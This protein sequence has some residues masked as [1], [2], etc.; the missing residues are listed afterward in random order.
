MFLFFL[1]LMCLI[2]LFVLLY[3]KVQR[4]ELFLIWQE[5]FY[6]G[7]HNRVAGFSVHPFFFRPLLPYSLLFSFIFPVYHP[8]MQTNSFLSATT[9]LK[10]TKSLTK[11]TISAHRGI[12]KGISIKLLLLGSN[13]T[14]KRETHCWQ[15]VSHLYKTSADCTNQP[16]TPKKQK[17]II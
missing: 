14:Q 4:Y 2:V 11:A 3:F 13:I 15:H 10:T 6:K 7:L 5:Y 12:L 17:K 9:F 16:P 1:L 8:S